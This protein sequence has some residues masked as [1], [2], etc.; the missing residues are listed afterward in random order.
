MFFIFLQ[1]FYNFTKLSS[2]FVESGLVNNKNLQQ[3]LN[4]NVEKKLLSEIN[5]ISKFINTNINT[6][7]F[8]LVSGDLKLV[9]FLFLNSP[10]SFQFYRVK[11][12]CFLTKNYLKQ[13]KMTLKIR[14]IYCRLKTNTTSIC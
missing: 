12:P 9:P 13:L 5:L 1:T 8:Y 6:D 11:I 2:I 3:V 4:I 14:I 7:D 10:R